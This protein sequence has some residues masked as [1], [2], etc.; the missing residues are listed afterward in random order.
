LLDQKNPLWTE[1][2]RLVDMNLSQED[3]QYIADAYKGE[4]DEEKV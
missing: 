2:L 3:L 4:T 1:L